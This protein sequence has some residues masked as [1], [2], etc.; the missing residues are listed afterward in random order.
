MWRL[1]TL[2][3]ALLT[4]SR[5]SAATTRVRTGPPTT[6][7]RINAASESDAFLIMDAR[8]TGEVTL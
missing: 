5:V 3:A 7:A 2:C 1:E 6:Q 4:A 8:Y